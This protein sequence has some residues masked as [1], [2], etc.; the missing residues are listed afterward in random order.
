MSSFSARYYEL[1]SIV[2]F[3]VPKKPLLFGERRNG[4]TSTRTPILWRSQRVQP[5]TTKASRASGCP[6]RRPSPLWLALPQVCGKASLFG[7]WLLSPPRGARRG[8]R[9]VARTRPPG[10]S[11]HPLIQP[12]W[13]CYYRKTKKEYHIIYQAYTKGKEHDY[14]E[15]KGSGLICK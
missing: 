4:D 13:R 6:P 15:S 1:Q 11:P 10:R 9:V 2:L 8:P 5:V 14:R 7:R 12:L 3:G